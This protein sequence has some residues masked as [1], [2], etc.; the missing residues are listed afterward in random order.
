MQLIAEWRTPERENVELYVDPNR[1]DGRVV[2]AGPYGAEVGADLDWL[3]D[4]PDVVWRG[5]Y[6]DRGRPWRN[7]QQAIILARIA[8]WEQ[9]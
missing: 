2:I 7:A 9:T 5:R 8:A 1:D 3:T 6:A 4:D